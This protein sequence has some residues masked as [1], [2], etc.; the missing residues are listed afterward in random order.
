MNVLSSY[1]NPAKDKLAYTQEP[2]RLN[3]IDFVVTDE[4]FSFMF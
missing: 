3:D 2:Q 4:V 1:H